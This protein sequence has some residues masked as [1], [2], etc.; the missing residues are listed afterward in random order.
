MQNEQ[1]NILHFDLD[2][3]F[4]SVERKRNPKL[5]GMPVIIGGQERGVVASCSYEARAFGVHSAMP[6]RQAKFL[7]PQGIYISGDYDAYTNESKAVT[8]VIDTNVPLYEKASI[9]EF[10]VDLTGMDKF[11]GS[12]KYSK[13]L[14]QK[15]TK[16][17]GLP[18]SLALASNKLLSKVATNEVK[19]NGQIMIDFGEERN[20]LAPLKVQ[21]LPG[22]GGQTQTVLNK[23][24]IY[25]IKVL[26]E[27][28][29]E[30]LIAKFGKP[31]ASLAK[32]SKGIDE[33]LII[34]YHESKSVSTQESF[35]SDTIDTEYMISQLSNMTERIAFE[36][37]R[38]D[39]L[40]GCVS[41][42]LRYADMNSESK[43]SS[44]RYT[45]QDHEL[46][47]AVKQLFKKLYTRRQRVGQLA[48]KFTDLIQGTLQIDLFAHTQEQIKLYQAIDSIKKQFGS[49][50]VLR[51]KGL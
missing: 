1:R 24:G 23:L 5:I 45:N 40:T 44:I 2:T 6:I 50:M 37:R 36:L 14:K 25:T 12:F 7:C 31:G 35:L 38:Q 39:K 30:M 3:F 15:I 32:R 33:S 11:F 43:Q 41:V 17:T 47:F 26:S 16:E 29:E 4:V 20:Y 13:E 46:I 21:K 51:A 27:I 34:P 48:V 10:Y 8:Q 42:R 18:I 19:P 28:P 22:V 49:T 9:D